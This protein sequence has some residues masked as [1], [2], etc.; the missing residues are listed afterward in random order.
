[1]RK[2]FLA[3]ILSGFLLSSCSTIDSFLSGEAGNVQS[4]E[5]SDREM[6]AAIAQARETLP[7]FIAAFQSP[8]PTQTYF[9][10]K[11][12]FP[13]G[14]G[15]AYEHLWISQLSYEAGQFT[16]VVGNEP[17]YLEGVKLGDTVIINNEDITDWMIIDNGRML[18]GF[19]VYV[20]LRDSSDREKEQFETE[21]GF[22]LSDTPL[23]P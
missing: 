19:T 7:E 16:G 5:S 15:T 13:F 20:L 11:V 17:V 12:E 18:G 4:V 14:D 8:S 10:I 23:L 2:F 21:A 3:C 6:N 22:T 9:G 1:M